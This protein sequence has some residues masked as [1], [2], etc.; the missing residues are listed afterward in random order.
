M[1]KSVL[2][3]NGIFIVNFFRCLDVEYPHFVIHT[4]TF[5][6]IL[7]VCEFLSLLDFQL[8]KFLQA[9]LFVNIC[10]E[11]DEMGKNMRR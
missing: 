10:R 7:Q 6:L 5:I 9:A 8:F 4:Y 1:K 3:F 2:L 11:I